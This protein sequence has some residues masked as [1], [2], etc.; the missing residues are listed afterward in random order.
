MSTAATAKRR[1]RQARLV[2]GRKLTKAELRDRM[3]AHRQ[4]KEK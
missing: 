3:I 4:R 2:K 1:R